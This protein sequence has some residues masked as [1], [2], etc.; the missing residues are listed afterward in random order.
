MKEGYLRIGAVRN[1]GSGVDSVFVIEKF[2]VLVNPDDET[3]HPDVWTDNPATALENLRCLLPPEKRYQVDAILKKIRTGN[4]Y[5]TLENI[6]ANASHELLDLIAVATMKPFKKGM[7]FEDKWFGSSKSPTVES[8]RDYGDQLVD[9][10][11]ALIADTNDSTIGS[12]RCFGI[13]KK[14]FTRSVGNF[15]AKKDHSSTA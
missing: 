7:A 9:T 6:I 10:S 3:N 14:G 5:P 12:H 4:M 2:S 11:K 8:I 13:E 15:W 1:P